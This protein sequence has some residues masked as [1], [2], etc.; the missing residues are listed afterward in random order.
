MQPGLAEFVLTGPEYDSTTAR[1]RFHA[2]SDGFVGGEGWLVDDIQL[3]PY[4]PL[5]A[6]SPPVGAAGLAAY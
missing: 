2:V 4:P 3:E 5:D 1:L 6:A